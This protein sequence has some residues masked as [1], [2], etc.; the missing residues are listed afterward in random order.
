MMR[1]REAEAARGG[2]RPVNALPTRPAGCPT[3]CQI[4]HHEDADGTSGTP[5]LA[6]TTGLPGHP[7]NPAARLSPMRPLTLAAAIAAVIALAGC[8]QS[9]AAPAAAPASPAATH[10]AVP[11]TCKQKSDQWKHANHGE[12]RR[13]K[14]AVSAFSSG[15]VTSAQAHALSVTAQLTEDNPPPACADPKGYFGRALA[16]LVTAGSATGGGGALSELGALTPMENAETSL[17]QLSAELHRTIH[18]S[19]L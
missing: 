17:S 12:L 16:E 19:K 18:S 3:W 6:A 11:L 8:G 2:R 13:F 14:A 5:P 9:A 7:P 4:T 1:A 15:T 10:A